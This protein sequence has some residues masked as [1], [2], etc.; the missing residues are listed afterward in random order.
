[1]QLHIARRWYTYGGA[2]LRLRDNNLAFITSLR[3]A[4]SSAGSSHPLLCH[5]S[6]GASAPVVRSFT[7]AVRAS[8][9]CYHLQ[10]LLLADTM[11]FL[12]PRAAENAQ[13][14][15]ERADRLWE[16]TCFE[17]F[18]GDCT[19]TD[20]PYL[21]LNFSPSGQWACYSFTSARRDMAACE[22]VTGAFRATWRIKCDSIELQV[23]LPRRAILPWLAAPTLCVGL[24][25]ILESSAGELSFWALR[26]PRDGQT[27]QLLPA[28]FH[29]R[30]CWLAR[31]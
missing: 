25:A 9:D 12:L 21:E 3:M 20:G 22:P 13:H 31:A 17:C 14:P 10:Y 30:D 29:R 15:G 1:M 16:H 8:E 26:H 19:Q 4:T 2:G 5:P 28:D 18:L 6:S 23:D 27:Q 7:A 24:T 11:Q